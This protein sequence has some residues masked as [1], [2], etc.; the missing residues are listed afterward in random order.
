MTKRIFIAV[1][2]E[3]GATLSSMV[4]TFKSALKEEKIKWTDPE[5]FHITLAFLGNTEEEKIK[6]IRD[7]L[8]RICDIFVEFDLVIKGAGLF[9]NIHDPR[10]LWTGVEPSEKLN[11]LFESVKAGLRDSGIRMEEKNFSPHLTLGRIKSVKDIDALKSLINRYNNAEIQRQKILEILLYES[12]LFD[13]GPV[14]R[15]IERF[16]I[17]PGS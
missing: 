4:S 11:I 2:I 1:K 5:N 9:K 8:K 17:L 7:M 3:P 6:S 14:Y 15:P 12:L 16:P 13:S 10:I